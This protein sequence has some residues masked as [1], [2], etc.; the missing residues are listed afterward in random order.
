MEANKI[1][2]SSSITV[3]RYRELEEN[4]DR[5]ALAEFIRERFDE[6]YFRPI[7]ST[8]V[9]YKH[10]FMTMA[11]CCLVIETLESFY[12]GMEGTRG[13]SARMFNDFFARDT[14]FKVFSG[15]D[16]WFYKDIR[17]GILHQ[18]EARA[19]W[20]I[21]RSGALLDMSTKSIN[22]TKFIRELVRV[23][24]TYA[25][26]LQRDD[27]LWDRFKNKMRAVCANCAST[28]H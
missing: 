20:R 8:P 11:V 14:V 15:G 24:D 2:L 18:S 16:N 17:C 10:G 5:Q 13:N 6:R 27:D 19:G 3:A 21:L 25:D 1:K 26:Q 9:A 28:A 23:V 22:A 12:Q 4:D 7:E